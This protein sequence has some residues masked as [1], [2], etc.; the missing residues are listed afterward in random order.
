LLIAA[1][2][3]G[4]VSGTQTLTNNVDVSGKPVNGQ[5]VTDKASADVQAQEAK[6][7][8]TKTPNPTAGS[9]GTDV[10]FAIDV[11][12]TGSA[13][14]QHVFVSD[15]LP[16]NMSYVSSSPPG[17]INV[18]QN[19]YWSD[20]GP[21]SSGDKKP[22]QIVAHVIASITGTQNLT[23]YVDVA[24]KHENDKNVTSKASANFLVQEANI[25]VTKTANPTIVSPGMTVT[26]TIVVKN[27][28]ESALPHTFVSDLLPTGM[29][30]VSY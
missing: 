24:G 17:G 23:N 21:M 9:P 25:S 30:Y 18:G 3:D 27:I 19:V 16:T 26:F 7:K 11:E 10:T 29:A 28:G 4:S 20:I 6:I 5:N 1:Y 12:N 15:L 8:V 14:L 22:L 13:V 2:I